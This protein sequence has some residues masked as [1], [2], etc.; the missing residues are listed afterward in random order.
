MH[1]Y[2][3]GLFGEICSGM[4]L[5]SGCAQMPQAYAELPWKDMRGERG[6]QVMYR[7][8]EMCE[9]MSEQRSQLKGCMA[10]QGWEIPLSNDSSK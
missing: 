1:Q 8:F 10:S 7:D 4:L 9:R 3:V 5:L 2:R 6:E